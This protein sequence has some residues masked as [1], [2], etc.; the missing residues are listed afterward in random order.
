MPKRATTCD[1]N[2]SVND[3]L[4]SPLQRHLHG[5]ATRGP[6]CQEFM[7]IKQKRQLG[8]RANVAENMQSNSAKRASKRKPHL[9]T[10][11]GARRVAQTGPGSIFEQILAETWL[12]KRQCTRVWL[13][14]VYFLSFARRIVEHSAGTFSLSLVVRTVSLGRAWEIFR[15]ELPRQQKV[16]HVQSAI[17]SSAQARSAGLPV[18]P[19]V[20]VLIPKNKKKTEGVRNTAQSNL[21]GLSTPRCQ[22]LTLREKTVREVNVVVRMMPPGDVTQADSYPSRVGTRRHFFV[23]EP[24]PANRHNRWSTFVILNGAQ[25][26]V[27][28]HKIALREVPILAIYRDDDKTN[29]DQKG[30]GGAST[31]PEKSTGWTS[32]KHGMFDS[33]TGAYAR[34]T[35]K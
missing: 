34:L 22:R 30:G 24:A 29:T 13:E 14:N 4:V 7:C 12:G 19:L 33:T 32:T 3:I 26:S 27:S 23:F 9:R 20:L 16:A 11:C 10:D 25:Q 1:V 21:V 15:A 18:S 8:A 2:C 5:N 17:N 35:L 6:S 31:E 28:R